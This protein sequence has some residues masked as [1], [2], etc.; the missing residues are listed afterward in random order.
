M[1]RQISLS[2]Y[3]NID[4]IILAVILGVIQVM[5]HYAASVWFADQ[6][7]VVSPVAI[8]T[9]LVMMRWG[10]WAAIH[11]MLGGIVYTAVAGGS[12]QQYLI[13]GIGNLLSLLALVM[14][15]L[16]GKERIRENVI[17]SLAFG[18]VVQ[19]LMLLGRA[20]IAAVLGFEWAACLGFITTDFL[21]VLLTLCGI[22]A[23]RRMDGLFEDQLQYLLRIQSEQSTEGREQL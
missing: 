4:L 8:V 23:V 15:R 12:V 6:L 5:I 22:W 2:Q 17:Y 9:A 14:F 21:S 13:Y 3:R 11:A 20:A 19:V 18:F 16:L 1:K 7:Y 10:A